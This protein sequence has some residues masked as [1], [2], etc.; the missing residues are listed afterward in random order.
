MH[1]CIYVL[2]ITYYYYILHQY[3]ITYVY[4]MRAAVVLPVGLK[5]NWSFICSS[6]INGQR[7]LRTTI[8]S[9]RRDKIGVT[10]IGLKS[11]K[12]RWM[13]DIVRVRVPDFNKNVVWDSTEHTVCYICRT[14]YIHTKYL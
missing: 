3:Y 6:S 7:Y 1:I 12:S 2:S 4:V 5:A 11:A 14:A 9:T 10:E 13:Y 8:F